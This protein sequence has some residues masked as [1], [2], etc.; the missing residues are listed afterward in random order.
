MAKCEKTRLEAARNVV[1]AARD[2]LRQYLDCFTHFPALKL[3][4]I[5]ARDELNTAED[6]I[7]RA[8][9]TLWPPEKAEPKL[10]WGMD[11]DGILYRRQEDGT[12]ALVKPG[13][14]P[15]IPKQGWWYRRR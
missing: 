12:F 1:R 6:C 15:P 3:E 13:E 8:I 14:M 10:Q 7:S 4:E 5:R 2:E 11:E 9:A